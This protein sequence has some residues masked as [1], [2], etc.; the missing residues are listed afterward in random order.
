MR[1]A[2]REDADHGERRGQP[3]EV[4]HLG[5]VTPRA[6]DADHERCRVEREDAVEQGLRVWDARERDPRA[7]SSGLRF[8]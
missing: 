8:T 1:V 3:A 6:D 2:A 4:P 5:G 7:W